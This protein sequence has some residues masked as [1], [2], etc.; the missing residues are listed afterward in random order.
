MSQL[1]HNHYAACWSEY[2]QNQH[3]IYEES[4]SCMH[5]LFHIFISYIEWQC[6]VNASKRQATENPNVPRV[7]QPHQSDNG[8]G[9][10]R[11]S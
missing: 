7:S 5:Y 3:F 4:F 1:D 10:S 2:R 9:P 6:A 11:A 8:M